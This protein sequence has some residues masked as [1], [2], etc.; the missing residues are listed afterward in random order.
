MVNGKPNVIAISGFVNG[1]LLYSAFSME[2]Q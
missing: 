2:R 1:A